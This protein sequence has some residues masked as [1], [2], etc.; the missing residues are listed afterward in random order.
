MRPMLRLL[1]LSAL[2]LSLLACNNKGKDSSLA[3]C[4]SGYVNQEQRCVLQTVVDYNACIAQAG[5]PQD[6]A[7]S[8]TGRLGLQFY[9]QEMGLTHAARDKAKQFASIYPEQCNNLR[10]VWGCYQQ[11]TASVDPSS[12]PLCAP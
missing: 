9:G 6:N 8:I 2:S 12:E 11:A 4:E 1:T 7:N 5:V 3:P 10:A